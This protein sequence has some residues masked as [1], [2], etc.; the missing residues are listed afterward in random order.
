MKTSHQNK[1]AYSAAV[2]L[3]VPLHHHLKFLI[4]FAVFCLGAWGELIFTVRFR[5]VGAA[6]AVF[7]L[8]LV[9]RL[10]S[11]TSKKLFYCVF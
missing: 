4:Y 7:M 8:L 1:K 2:D 9:Q 6:G 11:N 3:L 5:T 10:F